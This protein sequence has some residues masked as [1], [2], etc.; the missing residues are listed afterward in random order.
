MNLCMDGKI[1]EI[2]M[3]CMEKFKKNLLIFLP[4]IWLMIFIFIPILLLFKISL[5]NPEY[6]IP[7]YSNLIVSFKNQTLLLSLTFEHYLSVI[8][9][10]FYFQ[11]LWNSLK[12]AF[13]SASITLIIGYILAFSIKKISPSYQTFILFLILLP[14]WISFLIRIYSWVWILSPSGFLNKFLLWSNIISTPLLILHSQ[15]AVYIGILYTYLPFTIISVYLSLDKIS[16]KYIE[17]A[18]D[19]GAK[20]IKIFL[21]I[22]FPLSMPGILTGFFLVFIPVT[23]EVVIPLILGTDIPMIGKIILD[24][25]LVNRHWPL[26]SVITILFLT[27]LLLPFYILYKKQT[28]AFL[29]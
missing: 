3:G 1:P 19:L 25:Y 26:A 16:T 28:K 24:E 11:A 27:F 29:K 20:K 21:N 15:L 8:Y 10:S 7:P 14:L 9:D 12:I 17:A 22:I 4:F 6:K 23:G 13:I 18:Q 5:A 2:K